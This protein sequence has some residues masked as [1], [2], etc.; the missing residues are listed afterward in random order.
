[1]DNNYTINACFDNSGFNSD[2]SLTHL[3]L[4][5]ESYQNML[6]LKLLGNNY[7]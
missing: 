7:L 3:L 4:D 2:D 1:M 5:E 6:M